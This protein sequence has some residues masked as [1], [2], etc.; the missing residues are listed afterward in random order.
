MK[1]RYLVQRLDTE[2][3]FCHPSEVG[4]FTQWTKD[5]HKAHKWVDLDRC[6]AAART[7]DMVWGIPAP[8]FIPSLSPYDQEE[9]LLRD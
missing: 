5:P 8:G 1:K 9:R 2:M 4:E 6:I 3:F 7:S